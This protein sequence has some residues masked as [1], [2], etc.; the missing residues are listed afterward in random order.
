MDQREN[1]QIEDDIRRSGLKLYFIASRM[2]IDRTTLYKKLKGQRKF[3]EE[4]IV[5][6]KKILGIE[7]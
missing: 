7:K 3:T 4:E 1:A 2:G 6:L 5:S